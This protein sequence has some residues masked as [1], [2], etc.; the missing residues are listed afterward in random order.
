M[1]ENI[2]KIWG[3]VFAK[4]YAPNSVRYEADADGQKAFRCIYINDEFVETAPLC[5]TKKEAEM[6]L[7]DL[8]FERGIEWELDPR[9]H[10]IK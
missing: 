10:E 9:W 3:R 4:T 5:A 7:Q 8:M 2:K 6:R 1:N